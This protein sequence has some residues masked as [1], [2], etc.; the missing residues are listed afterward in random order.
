MGTYVNP[1]N[2]SF[3]SAVS[4][5]IYIDK[6]GLL[7][8]LNHHLGKETRYFAVSRARRFGKS[9]ACG[10]IDAYYSLGCDSR[11]LFSPFEIAKDEDF[12]KH[13]NKYNVLHFDAASFLN[14]TRAELDKYGGVLGVMEHK[15]L[16]DFKKVF[17]QSIDENVV[18]VSGAI[19]KVFEDTS[20]QFIIIIDE[21]ECIIRDAKDDI[22]LI[23]DYLK[24]L[25]GFFKT[26]ESKKFLAL[27]YITGILPIKKFNGESAMNN[28][29]E[30][31]MISPGDLA[32]WFGFTGEDTKRL[33]DERGADFD[34]VSDWYDGYLMDVPDEHIIGKSSKIHVFNP[35]SIVK[36]FEKRGYE[37][38]WKNTGAF[39]D[40]NRYITLNMSGLKDD[41][42]KMLTG[43]RVKVDVIAFQNDLTSYRSKDDVLTAL[44]HMGYLGYDS[45]TKEAF[46]PNREV[47]EV[48]E[49]AIKVGD[50][51]D[52]ID[53]LR[54]SDDLLNATWNMD[55]K[56]V[57][58]FINRSHQDYASIIK[59]HDENALACAIMMSYYTART[60]Y[61]VKREFLTGRGFA[62]IVF[63]P[64]KNEDVIPMVVELKWNRSARA[65]LKQIRDKEYEGFLSE[66]N[67]DILLAGIN[68]SKKTGKH[69]CRIERFYKE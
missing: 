57:A 32:I 40:L 27:G 68:Y 7:K 29:T 22:K 1:S 58:D 34:T 67:G 30:Y 31:T 15:L 55:N 54:A 44:I 60:R 8:I 63:I 53:A 6:T 4:S 35:N 13:L 12:E 49:S 14:A 17:P 9:Q 52:M 11:D 48:F 16:E 5:D 18:S 10:M 46:I 45:L 23:S 3:S 47:A 43:E 20:I 38:F 26:E 21:W 50:W 56:K 59:Y 39:A 51:D 64:K 19:Q 61:I 65:A 69:S 42:K 62:D 33:C 25:R 36:L 2:E 41:V 28:F 24:Y 66:Y 37:S